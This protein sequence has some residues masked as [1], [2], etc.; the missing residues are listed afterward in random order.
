MRVGIK[1]PKGSTKGTIVDDGFEVVST[2]DIF[3]SEDSYFGER[4][5]DLLYFDD[6]HPSISASQKIVERII[7]FL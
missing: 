7:K 2:S 1:R 4:A 5:G 3:C 6:D